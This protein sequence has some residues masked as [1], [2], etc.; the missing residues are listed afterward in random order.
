VGGTDAGWS[1]P[2]GYI[3]VEQNTLTKG[4]GT[5]GLAGLG[6]MLAQRAG[7]SATSCT[8]NLNNEYEIENGVLVCNTPTP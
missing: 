6:F 1:Y 2:P 8:A 4:F 5:D 7:A 3:P